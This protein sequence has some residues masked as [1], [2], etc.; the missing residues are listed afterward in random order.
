MDTSPI[1]SSVNMLATTLICA[2]VSLFAGGVVKKRGRYRPVNYVGW[3]LMLIGFGLL[4]LFKADS[5]T[6]TWAGFQIITAAG[7]G[8]IVS[9]PCSVL[10]ISTDLTPFAVVRHRVPDPCFYSC[11][12]LRCRARIPKLPAHVRTGTVFTLAPATHDHCH[13]TNQ[14]RPLSADLGHHNLRHHPTERTQEASSSS[15]Y[16]RVPWRY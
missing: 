1:R 13:L 7:I 12:S 5:S 8:I 14:H 6:R 4:T 11:Q 10:N 2:P 15:L 9:L 3:V 16:C